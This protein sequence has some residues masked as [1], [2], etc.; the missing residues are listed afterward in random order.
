MADRFRTDRFRTD[1]DWE[2]VRFFVAVARHGSLSAAARALGASHVTVARRV[3]GLERALGARLMERRR[4]G[5]VP[6][7]AGQS[8]L[9]AAGTMELAAQ[10]LTRSD[11]GAIAGLVRMTATQSVATTFLISRLSAFRERHP[12]LDIEL[13]AD[14]R[15]VSLARHEA[16]LAL[17]IGRPDDSDLVGRHL[18]TLGFGFYANADWKARLERGS[19]PEF[20][21]FDEGGAHLTEAMWLS[22]HFPHS[23][24][25]FRTN[26]QASQAIAARCGLGVALLPHFIG[27]VDAGLAQVLTDATPPARELWLLPRRDS[28]RHAPVRLAREFIIDVFRRERMLFESE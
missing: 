5:Y 16:D 20:V 28:K 19:A 25:A 12:Q 11:A 6:T 23:R 7:A 15:P 3:A 17:R 9:H 27:R 1:L 24:L 21:G 22:R 2:D 18:V 4:D 13:S 8:A 14:R 26:D 10:A